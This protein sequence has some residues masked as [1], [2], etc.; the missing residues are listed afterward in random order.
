MSKGFPYSWETWQTGV[1]NAYAFMDEME[2]KKL[3]ARGWPWKRR[4]E[5][6]PVV[7]AMTEKYL[8]R[9]AQ[10]QVVERKGPSRSRAPRTLWAA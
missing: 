7:K 4:P 1:K 9:R 6:Y 3:P 8:P 5:L 10:A 2:R